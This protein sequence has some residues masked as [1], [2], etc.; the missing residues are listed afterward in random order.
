MFQWLKILIFY[1][2]ILISY[3]PWFQ[4]GIALVSSLLLMFM[5]TVIENID[6]GDIKDYPDWKSWFFCL[7]FLLYWRWFQISIAL[8]SSLH[9]I[10]LTSV[11]E[12]MDCL[13]QKGYSWLL[14]I[15]L[16]ICHPRIFISYL[17]LFCTSIGLVS[18]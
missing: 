4:I 8:V 18:C 11:I 17:S 10:C 1:C 6:F 2:W 5:T 9:L 13:R 16:F 15:K 12:N 7:I 14:W 3:L